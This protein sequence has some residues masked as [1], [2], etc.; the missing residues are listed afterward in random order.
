MQ[1]RTR[2][3]PAVLPEVK[4]SNIVFDTVRRAKDPERKMFGYRKAFMIWAYLNAFMCMMMTVL[5]FRQSLSGFGWMLDYIIPISCFFQLLAGVSLFK[6]PVRVPFA[7][8]FILVFYAYAIFDGILINKDIGRSLFFTMGWQTSHLVDYLMV[9]LGTIQAVYC[10]EEVR[11]WIKYTILA[12]YGFSGLIGLMQL[13]NFA[14]ARNTFTTNM[15]MAIF[16]P[17]GTTDYPSQLGFQ[18]FAGL[19]LCGAPIVHRNLKTRE[20]LGVLFFALVVLCAQYRSMYYAGLVIGLSPILYF[21]YKRNK[22]LGVVFT[23][24]VLACITIPLLLFPKKFEYGLRPAANDPAILARQEAWKQ[25]E[26]IVRARPMTGI[27]ADPNLMISSKLMKIDKWSTSSL[28]NY[29][30][31]VFACFGYLG[32]MLVGITFMT[33]IGG[34]VLRAAGD[35]PAVREWAFVGV[36]TTASILVLSLTGNSIVYQPVG[37]FYTLVLGLGA[38]TWREELDASRVT[39]II[40]A[41]RKVFRRQLR[42]LG[43][44]A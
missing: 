7:A 43:V 40:I 14:W 20:W 38:L 4:G 31:T 39:G 33:I 29:Y 11:R 19:I 27:G 21:Q 36:V 1:P 41:L 3:L 22:N 32:V 13:G 2:T 34:C 9:G 28:D 42:M 16:R 10:G 15:E 6:I 37:F 24:V 12:F 17:I 35:A 8:V 26:P 5:I 23:T 18:G 25:L 30:I 44:N